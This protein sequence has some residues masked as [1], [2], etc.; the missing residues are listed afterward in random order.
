[1]Y[2]RIYTKSTYRINEEGETVGREYYYFD[3]K[4]VANQILDMVEAANIP[5]LRQGLV[6]SYRADLADSTSPVSMFFEFE[7]AFGCGANLNITN[8]MGNPMNTKAGKGYE[9]SLSIAIG[10]GGTQRDLAGTMLF[11]DI[12]NQVM[13]LAASISAQFSGNKILVFR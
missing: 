6:D 12:L 10:T 8:W 1:M 11:A 7:P 4:E 2:N 13:K 9:V 5:G 3:Y